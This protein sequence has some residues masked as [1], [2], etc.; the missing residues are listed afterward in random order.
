MTNFVTREDGTTVDLHMGSLSLETLKEI[1][2]VG[3]RWYAWGYHCTITS[4]DRHDGE[5][6][7]RYRRDRQPGERK[8]HDSYCIG[9][10]WLRKALPSGGA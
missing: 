2:P 7:V 4:H 9:Y 6:S 5:P 3:S 8:A 10:L 1:C